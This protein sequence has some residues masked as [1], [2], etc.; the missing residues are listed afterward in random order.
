MP[1][2]NYYFEGGGGGGTELSDKQLLARVLKHDK[3]ALWALLA[4]YE[5]PVRARYHTALPTLPPGFSEDDLIQELAVFVERNAAEL[6]PATLKNRLIHEA[7]RILSR[8]A[9]VRESASGQ[10]EHPAEF[11]EIVDRAESDLEA[12]ELIAAA[13]SA[14]DGR[15]REL[16]VLSFLYQMPIS[17]VAADM[18]ISEHAAR[19]RL[20]RARKRMRDHLIAATQDRPV[21][22]GGWP[23]LYKGGSGEDIHDWR[24]ALQGAAEPFSSAANEPTRA[25]A[26]DSP[27]ERADRIS[28]IQLVDER[29][30]EHPM[31]PD[32]LYT[33]VIP[34][35][36]S[37]AELQ[38]ALDRLADKE[39]SLVRV[40]AISQRSPVAVSLD[41]AADAVRTIEDIIRPSKR[42]H[43]QTMDY[44]DE[45]SA[46]ADIRARQAD[47][48]TRRA[49][50]KKELAEADKVRA[51]AELLREQAEST[52]WNRRR[53]MILLA[54]EIIDRS[55]P[56]LPD[57]DRMAHAIQLLGPLSDLVMSPLE[58]A[59]PGVSAL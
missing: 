22:S 4:R 48:A 16:V 11:G 38:V 23:Y 1:R 50:T 34:F 43:R 37:M 29:L 58:L 6:T 40:I 26:G 9:S 32:Y 53:E 8:E 30:G 12:Q 25:A 7:N 15:D 39:P 49:H 57:A 2:V 18:G 20:F 55:K 31:T 28:A 17:I 56:N 21:S 13:L 52:R 47:I 33:I 5:K 3:D 24:A 14:L 19:Q 10:V 51:E 44:L 27:M 35:L 54:L 59:G 41:G 46:A 36:A 45:Q 42:K